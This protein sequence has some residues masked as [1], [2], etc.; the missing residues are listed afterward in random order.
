MKSGVRLPS[1]GMKIAELIGR[2][3]PAP[4]KPPAK[5][6][7]EPRHLSREYLQT[8]SDNSCSLGEVVWIK[9]FTAC[10]TG[11]R[12]IAPSVKNSQVKFIESNP[13]VPGM[14]ELVAWQVVET[15]SFLSDFDE[16]GGV[17]CSLEPIRWN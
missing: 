12:F 3:D 11:A 5:V 13:Q 14:N 15:G 8:V 4:P 17:S 6:S 1:A 2:T 9:R 16:K 10:V 7:R